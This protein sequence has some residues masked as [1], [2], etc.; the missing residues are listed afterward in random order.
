MFKRVTSIIFII[1][2]LSCSNAG[3]VVKT[4]EGGSLLLNGTYQAC[5]LQPNN[6][7]AYTLLNFDDTS[8]TFSVV[9]TFY[10]DADC[11]GESS[12]FSSR[13]GNY[14][15]PSSGQINILYTD[16]LTPLYDIYQI[17][18]NNLRFGD[19]TGAYDGQSEATRPVS[20]DNAVVYIRN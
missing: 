7:Y 4:D 13:D 1:F 5:I 9:A 14:T 8:K 20:F 15:L 18:G 12:G 19:K 17:Q 3:D 11:I 2:I 10:T 16:S 6:T